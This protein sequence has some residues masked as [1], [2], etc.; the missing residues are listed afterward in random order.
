LNLTPDQ[1]VCLFFAGLLKIVSVM[2]FMGCG[3][4]DIPNNHILSMSMS[5]HKLNLMHNIAVVV[6]IRP[7][8][9]SWIIEY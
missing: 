6:K 4:C 2:T 1:V 5:W 9:S 8:W 3:G 7:L